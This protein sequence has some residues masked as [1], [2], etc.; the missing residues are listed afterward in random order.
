MTL[1][2]AILALFIEQFLPLPA[3]R[4]VG[5]PLGRFTHWLGDKF[6]DGQYKHGLVAWCLGVAVPAALVQGLY[7]F[8]LWAHPVLAA[9][10][11]LFVLYLTMGFR[12]FSHFFTDLRAALQA[13]NVEN[14]RSLLAQW[15]GRNADRL[16]S[17]EMA[18]VAIEQA[19]VASHRHVFAPLYCFA[20]LG[21]AGA[22]LYRLS[23]SFA[24]AW[25]GAVIPVPGQEPSRFGEFAQ[26]AFDAI[27]WLPIRLTATGFAVVGD[28]EDAIYC[29]RS[30][31]SHWPDITSGVLLSSGAGAMG[32][33]LGLPLHDDLD[34]E[35]RP[36]LGV[37]DPADV[38]HMQSTIGL[39]WRTLVL[40]LLV[41]ALFWVASWVG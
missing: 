11:G 20:L 30:Q 40:G 27:D 35:D 17:S 37:G 4:W 18:R 12:Q 33:S 25:G 7:F 24:Q 39:V 9:V 3:E 6:D 23:A 10:L 34:V 29:W 28:F 15:T 22:L 36:E 41:L 1:F 14:A 8:L 19:L 32:I 2:S 5:Q 38:D 26:R 16:N 13:D 21:P 31:A